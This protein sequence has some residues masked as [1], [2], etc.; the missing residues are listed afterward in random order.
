MAN[1]RRMT[2][3]DVPAVMEMGRA[4]FAESPRYRDKG[5]NEAKLL[6]MFNYIL[7][8]EDHGFFVAESPDGLIGMALGIL[9]PY[10]FSDEVYAC[11]LVVYVTPGRRGSSAA[12]RLVKALEEWAFSQGARELLL[13]VSTGIDDERAVCVYQKLGYTMAA[14]SLSKTAGS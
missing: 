1:I 10:F 14:H 8:A 2:P 6:Q 4:M 12:V 5:F 3:A 7:G 9:A 11:E 13:G